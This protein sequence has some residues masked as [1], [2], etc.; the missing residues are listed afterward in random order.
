ME[1]VTYVQIIGFAAESNA[2]PIAFTSY[3]HNVSTH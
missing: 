1:C 2:K 3:K